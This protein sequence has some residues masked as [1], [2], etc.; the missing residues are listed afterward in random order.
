MRTLNAR[1]APVL[2]LLLGCVLSLGPGAGFRLSTAS[3]QAGTPQAPAPAQAPANACEGS[4]NFLLGA[5]RSDI[6]G[7]AAEVGMMGY[8][9]VS[10]KTEGIHLRLYSR[11]FVIASPCNGRRVAFVSADLGMVFQAVKQQVVER[12]RSKL[13]DT[14][15]DD[16]VLLSAT[17]THSGPGGFSHYTFYNL[18]TFG[19]VPQNFEAIVSGIT[20]SILRANAR[21]ADGSLRLSSGDLHGASINRSPEAYLRN[22]ESERARYSDNVDDRMTLLRMTA[23]DGREL[24]LV[25]WFAVHATSIGNTN[26]YISGDNKGLA[27]HTFEVEKG[28][29]TPGGPDTF[30]AAFA[31]SNEGDVTPNILGGTNGGGANDFEDAALSAKKQYDFAEH[32]W[33]TAG[34][35]VMGGVDYRHAYVKMDAVDVAPAFTDGRTHR[36]CPAAIG[37]SML[38][39]AEDGPGFGSEGA[40]CENVHD[41]WSQFTCAAV[42]TPCQAEKPIVLEMGTMKPYP[43]SPEVLPLQ[44]VTVGPLALVAVPFELTTMA[45]RRLRDT[46]R[47]QLQGTGVTDVVIAGPANAYSGYVATREEYARQDYEGASTHFGP[48]TLGALQQSFTGLASALREGASVP[49]GPTPRDLRKVVVGLQP[50][51]VFDDKLLWVD[52]GAVSEEAKASYA[53]GDTA[54]VTFWGGHPR[55]DLKLGGTF[56]RVQR[57]EPDGTWR[58]VA[59][60]GDGV[61]LYHWQREFCVPTLACSKVRI[62]WP[63]PR[64]TQP[65]TYRLVHEGN[66]KSGW[67]GRIHPYAGSSRPFTVR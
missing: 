45:G 10:Q 44:V 42:T 12:L 58:D 56:L 31:N 48:W 13:G 30:V 34:M 47:A 5:A 20:D 52:F 2:G 61:A 32:L 4:A 53:R 19:F 35:P 9:Q 11:A 54:S 6:T 26:T 38:A 67:D 25:N 3:A 62:T 66:W 37:L 43:W 59:N 16:N 57:R 22:P 60:D 41:V 46:V 14:F 55:N 18:T 24:G 39:G 33:S 28:G 27:A 49:P 15:S 7:P 36:T 21:L 63:I 8:G 29:R 64:D 40:T 51:V 50:G 1:L 23:A 17:H 65:G